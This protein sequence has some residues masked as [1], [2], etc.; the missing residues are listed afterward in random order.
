MYRKLLVLAFLLASSVAQADTIS[1]PAFSADSGVAHLNTF[2]TTVVNV[3]NGNIE[4]SGTNGS[5]KN[6]KASSLGNLD[7]ADS[8]SPI[9]RDN[10]LLGNGV[11][12]F[13]GGTLIQ[14]TYAISGCVPADDTDLISDISAC[15]LY[16][17]GYRVSKGATALTYTLSSDNY[18]DLSQAGAYTVVPVPIGN[19]QPS[20]TANSG[21]L[22]KV[23]TNATEITVITDLARRTLSGL[24]VPTDFRTG[25]QVSRDSTTTMTVFPGTIEINSDVLTKTSTTTLNVGTAGDWAGGVSLRATSTYGYVGEDSSGNLKMHTTAPTHQNYALTVTAGKKRYA[26]WSS[27]VYRVIGWFYMNSTGSGELNTYEVGNIKEADVHNTVQI[28]SATLFSGASN[29]YV[30]DTSAL[31][32][33]YSSGN[34]VQVIYNVVGNNSGT[35]RNFYTVSVDS[36]GIIG[37]DRV[38]RGST[39]TNEEQSCAVNYM[40]PNVAQGTHNVQGQVHSLA[41]E[42]GYV[43]Q[44]TIQAEE[45]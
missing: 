42:T 45:K 5:T 32:H 17:N 31:I 4:G 35:Q 2:R 20:V 29:T 16:V 8:V 11:D 39:G 33:F 1:V 38:I 36:A 43:V 26:S 7:F 41:G 44:R 6:I 10:E 3:I 22:A 23:T 21:R 34:P 27:T 18:V 24:L 37:T 15:T 13:N 40:N 19:T 12:T 30:N 28:A 14:T 25:M 9:V